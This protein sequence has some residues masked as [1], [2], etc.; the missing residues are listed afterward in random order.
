[1]PLDDPVL[2]GLRIPP[3]LGRGKPRKEALEPWLELVG[4]LVGRGVSTPSRLRR[5]LGINYRT[6][7][8]WLRTVH[9]RWSRGLSDEL[10]SVRRE[11]LYTEADQVARTAWREAMADGTTPSEKAALFKVILLA[12]QRKATLT[13]LDTL[14]VRVNKRIEQHSTIELV[15]RVEQEHGL[16]PGALETVGRAAARLLSGQSPTFQP[17]SHSGTPSV[18]RRMQRQ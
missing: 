2:S 16:A 17:Y 11:R 18:T 6:A 13:G 7:Q 4:E 9:T 10:V 3:R 15:A 12:D 8:N 14:E 5:V 1:M